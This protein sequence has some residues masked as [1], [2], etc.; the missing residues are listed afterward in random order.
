MAGEGV[1]SI[2]MD[3]RWMMNTW[4]EEFET[5][6]IAITGRCCFPFQ[7]LERGSSA[8]V[9]H[10]YTQNVDVNRE[11]LTQDTVSKSSAPNRRACV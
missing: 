11:V 5:D 8:P 10:P 9:S 7:Q 3:N 2:Q 1:G 4:R 6:G